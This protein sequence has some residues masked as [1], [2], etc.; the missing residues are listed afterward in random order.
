MGEQGFLRKTGLWRLG[1]RKFAL[2]VM[3]VGYGEAPVAGRVGGHQSFTMVTKV[4]TEN[5]DQKLSLTLE[6][7]G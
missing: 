7:L 6:A 1:G 3:W 4:T 5:G 2:L